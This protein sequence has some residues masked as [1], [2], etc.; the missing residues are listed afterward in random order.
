MNAQHRHTNIAHLSDASFAF[1][2]RSR[3]RRHNW[4]ARTS[5]RPRNLSVRLGGARHCY[6]F[7]FPLT[8]WLCLCLCR[9]IGSAPHRC[10]WHCLNDVTEA[11]RVDT[12]GASH[13]LFW[14]TCGHLGTVRDTDCK[15]TSPWTLARFIRPGGLAASWR[16]FFVSEI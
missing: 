3:R 1:D 11:K 5:P 12:G 8:R 9:S 13:C 14:Q 16:P 15:A 4:F 10:H 6:F 7:R 2:C